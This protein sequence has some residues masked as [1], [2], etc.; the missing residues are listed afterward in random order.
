MFFFSLGSIYCRYIIARGDPDKS[1]QAE[2]GG[3]RQWVSGV[4]P[5]SASAW[6]TYTVY[7]YTLYNRRE[8]C[9]CVSALLIET[10][11]S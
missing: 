2:D 3:N 6:F 9:G 8:E 10:M 7:I 11:V 4:R 1:Y 5:S